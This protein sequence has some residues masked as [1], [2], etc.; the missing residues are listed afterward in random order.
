[1]REKDSDMLVVQNGAISHEHQLEVVWKCPTWSS[2]SCLDSGCSQTLSEEI[3]DHLLVPDFWISEPEIKATARNT[4]RND[5]TKRIIAIKAKLEVET[6][7][8]C[9]LRLSSTPGVMRVWFLRVWHLGSLREACKL[10]KISATL[11][12]EALVSWLKWM[13]LT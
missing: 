4:R 12:I 8:K 5:D 9:E 6:I 10:C 13:V 3:L 1:M 11:F 7:L 2:R